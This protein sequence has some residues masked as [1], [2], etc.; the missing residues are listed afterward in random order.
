[1][2]SIAP[3]LLPLAY[4]SITYGWFFLKNGFAPTIEHHIFG[5]PGIMSWI[6]RKIWLWLSAFYIPRLDLIDL[7]WNL[8]HKGYKIILASNIGP[9]AL[10]ELKKRYPKIFVKNEVALFDSI[11]QPKTETSWITKPHQEFFIGLKEECLR[12]WPLIDTVLFIDNK[13]KNLKHAVKSDKKSFYIPIFFSETARLKQEL[14]ILKI[15]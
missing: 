6:L 7:I 5:G 1:M 8:K 3:L 13:K 12:T 15:M 11:W 2:V 4:G 9:L 10:E 14:K